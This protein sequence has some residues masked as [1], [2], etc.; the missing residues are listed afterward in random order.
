MQGI[1]QG[2][3]PME[4]QGRSKLGHKEK[5]NWHT[6]VSLVDN[7]GTK[8]VHWSCLASGQDSQAL[9][10]PPPSLLGSSITL[11]LP[12]GENALGQ[13]NSAAETVSEED[14]QLR[15]QV[16]P[17]CLSMFTRVIKFKMFCLPH[18]KRHLYLKAQ[19]DF[20]QCGI[21]NYIHN[22]FEEKAYAV[23]D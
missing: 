7:S 21:W 5:S 19:N 15:Q 20:T 6:L 9:M 22:Q 16:F 12:L 11:P 2:S 17:W 23:I 10:L 1:Y 14:Q 13:G 8:F 18:K 3:A 4:G